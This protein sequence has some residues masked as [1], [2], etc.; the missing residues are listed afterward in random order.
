M[1]KAKQ[2]PTRQHPSVEVDRWANKPIINCQWLWGRESIFF[3]DIILGDDLS[4]EQVS[5][6]R[7][8]EQYKLYWNRK[9]I[10]KHGFLNVGQEGNL[11]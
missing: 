11:F 4:W 3:K 8:S 6:P 10:N 2:T 9:K 7:Q 1:Q 5:D